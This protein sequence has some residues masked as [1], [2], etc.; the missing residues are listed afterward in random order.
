MQ[1][2]LTVLDPN[3]VQTQQYFASKKSALEKIS[4]EF[5][6]HY[7]NLEVETLFKALMARERLGS[8]GIGHGIA[9][10]HCRASGITQ[11]IMGVFCLAYP[12]KFDAIDNQPVDIFIVLVVPEDEPKTHLELLAMIAERFK[13][14]TFCTKI[15]DTLAANEVYQLIIHYDV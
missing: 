6:K 10:P 5:A 15:R 1:S 11:C 14:Q 3:L 9:I 2:L 8:T 12:V 4:A 7:S 13:N